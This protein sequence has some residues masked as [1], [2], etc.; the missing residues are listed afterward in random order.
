MAADLSTP[1][2]ETPVFDPVFLLNVDTPVKGGVPDLTPSA[3]DG[4]ANIPFQQ[5]THRTSYLKQQ[6]ETGGTGGNAVGQLINQVAH[7]FAVG[8]VLRSD[9]VGAFV[10]SQADTALNSEVLGIVSA[11]TDVDN[12]TIVYSGRI[13]LTAHGFTKTVFLSESTAGDIRDTA[14]SSGINKPLGQVFDANTIIIQQIRGAIAAVGSGDTSVGTGLGTNDT[15]GDGLIVNQVAHG[16]AVGNFVYLDGSFD[17]V[18]AQADDVLT[19]QS[20]GVISAVEDVDNF[21]VIFSGL[22]TLTGHGFASGKLYLSESVAGDATSTAPTGSNINKPIGNVFDANTIL[23][24]DERGLEASILL[25]TGGAEALIASDF[26]TNPFQRGISFAGLTSNTYVA[27]RWEFED[28][29]G[30]AIHSADQVTGESDGRKALRIETTTAETSAPTAGSFTSIGQH[31]EGFNIVPLIGGGCYVSGRIRSNVTG[32]I[33][34]SLQNLGA[35]QSYVHEETIAVADIF[36]DVGFAVPAL[37]SG[38]GT[39]DFTIGRGLSVRTLFGSNADVK[40]STLDTWQAANFVNSTNAIDRN[41]TLNAYVEIDQS[42]VIPGQS[43]KPFQSKVV[44]RVLASC[45]RYYHRVTGNIIHFAPG[46]ANT[47][48]QAV[49]NYDF[50]V[51]MRASPAVNHSGVAGFRVNHSITQLT[52]P[53]VFTFLPTVYG[54]AGNVATAAVL[55]AEEGITMQI[56]NS[57][58]FIESDAEL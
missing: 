58:H 31:I 35:D 26:S 33:A 9:S 12:F 48:S 43:K 13:T 14:P 51:V 21:T 1:H 16:L 49:P 40:T 23:I 38:S 39:W 47:T 8:D 27:D 6:I 4:Q 2:D 17:F 24:T 7:G 56:I 29:D 11:V 36:Q 53:T 28:G 41:I 37:P 19:A 46:F 55:T 22:V 34:I 57:S 45:Q 54:W 30:D 18:L 20:V 42:S 44:D 10:K 50:P 25:P 32:I 15:T 52:T 3:Q 5:L